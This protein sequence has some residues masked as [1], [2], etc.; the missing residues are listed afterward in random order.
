M[1]QV[2]FSIIY[3]VGQYSTA[4]C[5]LLGIEPIESTVDRLQLTFFGGIIHENTSIEYRIIERQLIMSKQN[6][7][8]F[9]SRLETALSKYKL[10]KA[11]EL[12]LVKPTREKWKTTVKCA[13]QQYWTEKWE[14]E[15]SEKSTMKFIDIKTRPN[16]NYHQIWKFT[17]NKTLEVKKEEI[18]AKLITRIYTLQAD[19]AKFSRNVEQDICSLCGSAK[20]DTVH[21]MLECKALNPERDKHLTTLKS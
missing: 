7:T 21:F 9:I 11:Q 6:A 8:S 4:N 12:L 10:P 14:I 20:E 19:R 18:K 1:L 16:G 17:S 15:K 5:I 2:T 3:Q 13:I